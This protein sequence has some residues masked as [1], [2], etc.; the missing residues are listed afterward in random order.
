MKT[1][2][3]G[4]LQKRRP[5]KKKV[6]NK[7]IVYPTMCKVKAIIFLGLRISSRMDR[8]FFFKKKSFSRVENGRI[9]QLWL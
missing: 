8:I 4:P 5:E 7:E 9:S 1:L 3:S 2:E 6:I